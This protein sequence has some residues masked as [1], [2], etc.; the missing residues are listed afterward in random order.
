[1]YCM[2]YVASLCITSS[3]Y[4]SFAT[5]S[6]LS[7]DTNVAAKMILV[8]YSIAYVAEA[9]VYHSHDYTILEEFK[10]YFDIGVFYGREK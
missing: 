7:K 4:S 5:P 8:E 6:I 2:C 9:M 1:M 3:F 10:R